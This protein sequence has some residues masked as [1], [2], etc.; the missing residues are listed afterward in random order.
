[1]CHDQ[2]CDET[3]RDLSIGFTSSVDG[4]STWSVQQ[5]AGPFKNT[6]C[7][8]TTSGYMVGDYIGIS[9][10]DGKDIPVFIVESE[11]E[12]ELGDLTSCNVWTASAT[13]S[14]AS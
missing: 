10:V 1:L 6:W 7:P 13:I 11:A 5:L 3:T 2:R 12:C 8:L 14:L 9:F 4:S